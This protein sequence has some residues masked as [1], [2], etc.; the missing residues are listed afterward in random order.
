[1]ILPLLT[2]RS[3]AGMSNLGQESHWVPCWQ[4]DDSRDSLG[5]LNNL[6]DRS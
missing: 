2:L 4:T 6:N 3:N 5:G 1:M